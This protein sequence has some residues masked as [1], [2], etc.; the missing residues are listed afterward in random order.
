METL[1]HQALW[2]DSRFRRETLESLKGASHLILFDTSPLKGFVQMCTM[3]TFRARSEL[4]AR[5]ELRTFPRAQR[6]QDVRFVHHRK[7]RQRD[8]KA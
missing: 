4:R 1:I 3:C 6:A 7:H 5:K 8:R 2:F